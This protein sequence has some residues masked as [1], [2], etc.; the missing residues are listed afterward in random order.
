MEYFIAAAEMLSFSKAAIKCYVVQPTISHQISN[1]EEELGVLLFERN[2][3]NIKLTKAGELV[4]SKARELVACAGEIY[5]GIESLKAQKEKH[6]RIG[7]YSTCIDPVFGSVVYDFARENDMDVTFEHLDFVEEDLVDKLNKGEFDFIITLGKAYQALPTD[8]NILYVPLYAS[9][10]KLVLP[11]NHPLADFGPSIS[12]ARLRDI[13]GKFLLYAPSYDEKIRQSG[14]LWHSQTLSIP[15]ERI[16]TSRSTLDMLLQIQAGNALGLMVETE[17]RSLNAQGRIV[18]L[19]IEGSTPLEIG[20]AYHVG[21][22]TG[23]IDAFIA[24]TKVI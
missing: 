20:I 12:K 15:P 1:L 10:V 19:R 2:R 21:N 4:L 22:R 16:E 9:S 5:T 11:V 13:H 3:R 17:I 6:L 23:V 14:I 24:R 7:Y 8:R 18:A